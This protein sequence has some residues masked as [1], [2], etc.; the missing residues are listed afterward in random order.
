MR[1]FTTSKL[2]F[3]SSLT[4]TF[5]LL[6]AFILGGNALLIWQFRIARQQTD[7]LAIASQQMMAILRLRNSLI[8]FHQSLDELVASRDPKALSLRSQNLETDLLN[9]VRQTRDV[10][11]ISQPGYPAIG[12]FLPILDAIE[13]GFPHQ[14]EAITSLAAMGDWRAVNDRVSIQLE[15]TELEVAALAR[16][17]DRTFTREL[18]RSESD[19]RR[20]QNRILFLIPFLALSTF[21]IAARFVWV[22]A[23]RVIQLKLE[24][25]LNERM[26]ITRDLHD[27]FLQTIQGSK[28]FA[29]N[30]L[31]KCSDLVV[32][33]E[34]IA[35]LAGWLDRAG[36]EARS[37]LNSLRT[38]QGDRDDFVDA[39]QAVAM[40]ARTQGPIDVLLSISG[41]P[42]DA[43]PE[44]QEEVLRI[45]RE[46]ITNARKHSQGKRAEF[47]LEYAENL[48]L[49]IS[50]N[51]K[52]FDKTDNAP[53]LNGHY[54]L[55]GM[56]ERAAHI[57]GKLT[58]TSSA[59]SGTQV[60]LVV[61]RRSLR[62]RPGSS[63]EGFIGI[64]PI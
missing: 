31:A 48:S 30:I 11:T 52:G 59:T 5:A 22:I 54:G 55:K 64:R 58:I 28:L 27:T 14:L 15:P 18:S 33:R 63:T 17:M 24:E 10:L 34:G 26:R 36:E 42:V 2:D 6:V 3:G 38:T 50:D 19:A 1:R 21:S 53:A 62:Q 20:L 45:A 46:A 60:K 8:A 51:G 32:M 41:D 57:G 40:D 47:K 16:D 12:R 23:R 49:T 44:V 4:L 9:Q 13:I 56:H 29:Q 43:L 35:Q 25:R 39:L 61:P 37:A 7:R